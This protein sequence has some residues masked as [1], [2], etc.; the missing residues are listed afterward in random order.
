[1]IDHRNLPPRSNDA[2]ARRLCY[3]GFTIVE[4]LVVIAIIGILIVLLLPAINAARSEA[5]RVQCLNNLR[6]LGLG[7]LSHQA[8]TRKFPVNRYGDYN[9]HVTY[10]GPYE[11]SRSWSWLASILP[12]I[13]E[14]DLY[15]RAK[16]PT[17]SLKDAPEIIATNVSTFFCPSD[18]LIEHSPMVVDTN[19]LRGVRTALTNY[20]GVQGANF[21]YGDYASPGANGHYDP[22]E[23]GDGMFY[24]MSWQRR[25]D[26]RAVKD[27]LSKTMMIG[28][29]AWNPV[30]A[31]CGNGC[32]GFGFSWAHSVESVA[33]ANTP[34]NLAAKPGGGV[35]AD[36]DWENMNAFRST[37]QGGVQFCF[38][39]G[40]VQFLRD[41]IELG[42]YRALATISGGEGIE[43]KAV[44]D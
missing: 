27:G 38:G 31:S 10:G 3:G 40:R 44:D 30:R 9:D 43:G 33:N 34:P 16:I 29:D 24:A 12:F 25:I 5:R 39:D 22:W 4:L 13:E 1:M 11:D 26:E 19:Y 2:Q 8:A 20:K 28:E 18:E 14:N 35:Y 36:D 15:V 42:V 32:F 7:V 17:R 6:Q 41:D 37:H 23:R 21:G